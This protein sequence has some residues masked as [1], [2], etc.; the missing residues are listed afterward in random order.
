MCKQAPKKTI[1]GVYGGS[2]NPIHLGHTSMAREI[3]RQGL[4]DEMW[5]VVSPQNPLKDSGLWDDGFRLELARAAVRD[6]EA[7]EVSDV[8]FGLPKPNYMVNTLETL[9]AQF[10]DREFVLVIGQDNWDCFHR[11]YKW[12]DI[13]QRYRLMVLPRQT[14]EPCDN[15]RRDGVC[16]RVTFVDTPLI[17]ISSTW[18]RS[19]TIDN[20]QYKGEGLDSKVWEMIREK[21]L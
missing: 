16:G 15:A 5:L 9:S 2:F 10:P 11:W 4:V 17:N 3:V 14:G 20:P 8:E 1:T 7:V 12:E 18:I 6:V 13:L 21:M 19:Q